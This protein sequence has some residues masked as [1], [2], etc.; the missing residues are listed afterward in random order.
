MTLKSS[1]PNPSDKRGVIPFTHSRSRNGRRPSGNHHRRTVFMNHQGALQA[2]F[3][4]TA[5]KSVSNVSAPRGNSAEQGVPVRPPWRVHADFIL[6][7]ALAYAGRGWPVF[8]CRINGKEPATTH[9]F[10]DASTDLNRVLGWFDSGHDYN[11]AIRTGWPGPDVLDV[12]VRRTGNGW[13]ALHRSDEAGLLTGVNRLVSTPSTGMHLYFTGT[14]Q[15]CARLI[16]QHIDLKAAGGYVLAPPSHIVLADYSGGYSLSGD[17]A[18]PATPLNWSAVVDLCS[19][20]RAR[21]WPARRQ[22]TGGIDA[23]VRSVA[24][25]E[26]GNRNNLLF[27]AACR[28][29][30]AGAESLAPLIDAAVSAGLSNAE[31]QRTVQSAVRNA[32]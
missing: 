20:R 7:A 14:D 23:L 6:Q 32:R 22:S 18:S 25:A 3:E 29:V 9:G 21:P 19:P 31:A 11:L 27:W 26:H 12:D 16:D 24:S 17:R 4:T 28:A 10:L 2:A 5:R 30:E 15:P 8:P 13:S 1:E